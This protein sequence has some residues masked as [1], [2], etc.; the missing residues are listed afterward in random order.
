[1]S[2]ATPMTCFCG[3]KM[4]K[5]SSRA[6]SSRSC[7]S[8]GPPSRPPRPTRLSFL[9]SSC[10]HPKTTFRCLSVPYVPAHHL[11]IMGTGAHQ[12]T[13]PSTPCGQACAQAEGQ[14]IVVSTTYLE[15]GPPAGTTSSPQLVASCS[16]HLSRFAG[17]MNIFLQKIVASLLP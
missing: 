10:R 1:V 17:C 12:R 15:E 7:D 11:T 5:S 6:S 8:A 2:S 4:S 16:V 13:G 3:M 14:A 9:R